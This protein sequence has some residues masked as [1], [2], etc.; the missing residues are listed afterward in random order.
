VGQLYAITPFTQLDFPGEL[1]CIAW[2]SGC[3]LRC[4]YCHNPDIF[5]KHGDKDD[6]ELLS[7]L[8]S[9]RGRLTGVVFSG[10]EATFCPS[11]P[12]LARQAK[13][14]G[15][16]V[17]LDTNGTNPDALRR[18]VENRLIDAVALD[19]KCPPH[20]A[21]QVIGTTQFTPLFEQSL[22]YLIEEH[23][24]GNIGLEIRT[25]C[26]VGILHEDDLQWM[27]DDLDA[28]GYCGDYWLQNIESTGEKTLGA[29]AS[30][31]RLHNLAQFTLPKNTQ[32]KFRNF[33]A[34]SLPQ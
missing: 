20:L 9:R 1:A 13:S 16:K 25:T 3:N 27:I 24:A 12:D 28:R 29:I 19:Y 10:G 23:R 8:E 14:M 15:F 33:P 30:P 21:Q 4:V 32:L 11:L 18:L 26:H 6:S 2:F 7:F 5:L 34:S 31:D 17:K 22:A